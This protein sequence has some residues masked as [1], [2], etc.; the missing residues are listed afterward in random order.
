MLDCSAGSSGHDARH[1]GAQVPHPPT[2]YFKFSVWNVTQ[3]PALGL[4]GVSH[5]WSMQRRAAK[6]A[7][8]SSNGQFVGQWKYGAEA[9]VDPTQTHRSCFEVGNNSQ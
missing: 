4:L 2:R 5:R 6:P 9:L 7:R 8:A 3:A 1:P